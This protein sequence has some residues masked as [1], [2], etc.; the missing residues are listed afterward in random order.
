MPSCPY[1]R[2]KMRV[3]ADVVNKKVCSKCY[4]VLVRQDPRE[5]RE[6]FEA[7]VAGW[8]VWQPTRRGP[9]RR[10]EHPVWWT[11][12]FPWAHRLPVFVHYRG[13]QYAYRK[14]RR[15]SRRT[16]SGS[17]RMHALQRLKDVSA[18]GRLPRAHRAVRRR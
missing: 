7:L 9:L 2:A 18:L 15:G 4:H 6:G 11:T 5:Q 10:P 8:T 14:T 17:P 3:A 12:L 1:E 16:T 13:E